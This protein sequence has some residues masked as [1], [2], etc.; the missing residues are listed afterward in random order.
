[1]Y[2]PFETDVSHA[3]PGTGFPMMGAEV[4][5][6]MVMLFTK[7]GIPIGTHAIGDR[8][9]DTVVDAY[10]DA[11]KATPKVG[12]RHSLIHAN[13]PHPITIKMQVVPGVSSGRQGAWRTKRTHIAVARNQSG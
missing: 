12:L 7:A 9:I 6:E 2:Q 3:N 1:M 4:Y 10:A 5:R 13:L 8:A 11:L